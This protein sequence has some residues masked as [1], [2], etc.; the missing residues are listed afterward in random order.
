V[1]PPILIVYTATRC[2]TLQH[3]SCTTCAAL[4]LG[5]TQALCGYHTANTLQHTATRCNTLQHAATHCNTL[6][7]TA[8][9]KNTLQQSICG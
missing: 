7:H 5:L 2:N 8:T 9:Q 6:Q 1:W 4:R 3:F